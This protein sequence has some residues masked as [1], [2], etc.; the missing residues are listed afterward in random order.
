MQ[1]NRKK[2]ISYYFLNVFLEVSCWFLLDGGR[3]G[4]VVRALAYRQCGLDF[5]SGP[6]VIS[7]LSLLLVLALL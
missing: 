1:T 5:S 2:A 6:G 3:D 7:G 4:A